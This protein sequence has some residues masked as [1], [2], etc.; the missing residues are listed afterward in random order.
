MNSEENYKK[1]LEQGNKAQMRKLLEN[2]NEKDGW[3]NIDIDFAL[4]RI[5]DEFEELQDAH[6]KT[7]IIGMI[8]EAADIANFAH[9]LI[10]KCN[11]IVK[12]LRNL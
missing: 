6:M 4:E 5:Q 8:E 3:D 2:D 11:R 7:D 10:W 1:L 9:M 12:T